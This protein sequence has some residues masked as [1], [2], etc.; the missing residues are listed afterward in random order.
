PHRSYLPVLQRALADHGLI[1]G[2]A[3]ITG[4]GLID[5][6]PRILPAGCNAVIERGSWPMP[7]LFRLVESVATALPAD[8]LYR[9][10]N[11]GIGMVVVVASDRT[12][13]LRASIDEETWV[14]GHLTSNLTGGDRR[15]IMR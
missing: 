1:K 6:L 10:L 14:I 3:H 15:V 11:M 12:E 2:L 4:G 9:T 7:P 5:N 8:E 13:Q